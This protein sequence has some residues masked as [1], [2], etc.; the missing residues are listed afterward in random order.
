[1]KRL[2]FIVYFFPLIMFSQGWNQLG[3]DIDG[4]AIYDQ[5]GCSVSFSSN[6]SI[7]G[8]GAFGNNGNGS[9]TGHVRIYSFNGSS[10]VQL[11]DDIN[12]EASNDYSGGSVSLSDDG[13]IVAIGASE[14]DGNGSNSGHV[15]V[16]QFDGISWAQIGQD[17]D[18]EASDDKSG[19]SVSLSSDGSIVAIGAYGNAENGVYSGNVSV[20]Y[21]DNNSWIQLG[22]DID[23]ED[24][25]DQNGYSVSL[26]AD[27]FTLAVGA[28]G[29]DGNGSNS[30]HVRIF[31][32]DGNSWAQLGNDIDGEA[33]YD[34]SGISVSLSFDGSTVAIGAYGNDGNSIDAGHVRIFNF[35]G[36]SWNQLGNNIEGEASNDYSGEYVSLSSDGSTVAIGAINNNGNGSMSGHVRIYTMQFTAILSAPTIE[37][38]VIAITDM[39]GRETKI[40]NQPLLYLY[41]DGTVEKRIVVE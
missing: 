30:G 10:W 21:Y 4:E 28:Y 15:R 5:S 31:S 14:N 35:N 39:L 34:Y 7:V 23:G 40:T 12:G 41:D 9:N 27:G 26:S 33:S 8:V 6:G 38:N 37:K 29:N 32:F 36:T 17:I 16:Y 24:S 3:Q 25:G 1:M 20:Y 2:L 19:C 11:G 13:S 18:G 22:N